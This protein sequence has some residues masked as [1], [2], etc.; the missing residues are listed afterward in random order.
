FE[1]ARDQEISLYPI[2]R[3]L[4]FALPVG[5]HDLMSQKAETKTL[6]EPLDLGPH[7][8]PRP[9]SARDRDRGVVNH[10]APARSPEKL[11][12]LGQKNLHMEPLKPWI[13]LHVEHPRIAQ[14]QAGALQL[15]LAAAK[16]QGV[17]R[18]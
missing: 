12:S 6:L 9:R 11:E 4:N 1:L 13:E 7:L 5:M 15:R 14:H 10:T 2:V 8:R 16:F 3:S 18:G 17:G